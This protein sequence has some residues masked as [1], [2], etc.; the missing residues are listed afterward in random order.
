MHQIKLFCGTTHLSNKLSALMLND[1]ANN[2]TQFDITF[3]QKVS[4][5]FLQRDTIMT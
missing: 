3:I 5:L 2:F 1:N 4:K